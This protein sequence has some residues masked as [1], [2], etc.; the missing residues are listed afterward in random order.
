VSNGPPFDD[1]SAGA[2]A[3]IAFLVPRKSVRLVPAGRRRD[4]DDVQRA[5]DLCRNPQV[6]SRRRLDGALTLAAAQ[7]HPPELVGC[8]RARP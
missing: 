6:N 4:S 8:D 1:V 3:P 2:L 7:E 5:L